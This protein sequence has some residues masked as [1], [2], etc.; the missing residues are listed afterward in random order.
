MASHRCDFASERPSAPGGRPA[1]RRCELRSVRER[2]SCNESDREVPAGVRPPG[3][4]LRQPRPRFGRG[5]AVGGRTVRLRPALPTTRLPIQFS[6]QFF[7]SRLLQ[8]QGSCTR[9]FAR[10]SR[11]ATAPGEV[12]QHFRSTNEDRCKPCA[13]SSAV[14][15]F[16]KI[17]PVCN[18]RAACRFS[19]AET[20]QQFA[21]KL[22]A[23]LR[24]V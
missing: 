12:D 11:V 19:S 17:C 2:D 15:S 5:R 20:W 1:Q 16:L 13:K 18:R 7:S 6:G 3:S 24:S 8:R 14:G 9:F 22:T 10:P 23:R 21:I 4:E